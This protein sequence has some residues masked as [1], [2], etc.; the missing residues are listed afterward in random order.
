MQNTNC[1]EQ[2]RAKLCLRR[3]ALLALSVLV[4]LIPLRALAQ[5]STTTVQGTIYRADGTAASGTVLISWLAFTTAQNQAVAAGNL[6]ATIGAN[7]F[8][9]VNL[10]PNAGA[11][12]A[13]SYYTAVYHLS[14][15]TVNQEYWVVPAAPTAT[16]A[17]VRAELQPSTVAVQS[18]TPAYVNSA[19]SSISSSYLPLTGGTLTGPLTLSSDP[20]AASQ[21]ATKH[22][23]DQL[24]A[25]SLPLSGG[26]VA[27]PL[28]AQQMEGT[29]DADQYNTGGSTA[30]EIHHRVRQR[31]GRRPR[32]QNLVN[33]ARRRLAAAA[34]RE[35]AAARQSQCAHRHLHQ[36]QHHSD[37]RERNAAHRRRIRSAP[38]RLGVHAGSGAGPGA[39]LAR[40][41]HLH[42]APGRNRAVLHPH[43]R[44]LD[45]PKLLAVL[46][47][48]VCESADLKKG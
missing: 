44:R 22:Y 42:R 48:G 36:R 18:V 15:G 47:G 38:S 14:D 29:L 5:V 31:L 37:C 8:L 12:P 13:G 45:A 40:T 46:G 11:L 27:G 23:A 24:F 28:N 33:R 16:V 21:A 39:A 2:A 30:R 35:H 41:Q 1:E 32:D 25:Q 26:T 20:M 7:G 9:S 10:T 17:A 6:S 4:A 34:A 43:V 19:V 3:A